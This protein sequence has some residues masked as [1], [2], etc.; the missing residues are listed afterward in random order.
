MCSS[1]SSLG[2]LTMLIRSIITNVCTIRYNRR[3]N[4]F[5]SSGDRFYTLYC[6]IMATNRTYY[7]KKLKEKDERIDKLT[8]MYAKL[9]VKYN[10][11]V[12]N[13]YTAWGLIIVGSVL[14][15]IEIIKGLIKIYS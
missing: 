14:I 7:E 10:K 6:I 5:I 11:A 1:Y 12:F 8:G 4:Y 15:V 2:I 9:S 3:S 13:E